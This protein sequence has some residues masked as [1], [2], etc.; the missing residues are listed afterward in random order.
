MSDIPNAPATPLRRPLP[1]REG[2]KIALVLGGGN[3][4]GAY[5]AGL[6]QALHEAGIE[7]DWV[8]GT[9]IGAVVGAV[10]AGNSP[11]ER[12][13]KLRDLWRPED[14]RP[15]PLPW[16]FLPDTWR[17]SAAA[18]GT[19]LTG[20]R[21]MF[22]PFGSSAAWW[23]HDPA[24]GSHAIYDTHVLTQTLGE[25]VNFELLNEGK[26][27]YTAA[28]VY[29]QTGEEVWIDTATQRVLPDHVRASASLLSAFPGIEVDGRL[30]VDG[31]LSVNVPLDPV[32][33]SPG[34][35]PVLCIAADLLPLSSGRPKTLGEVVGRTQDLIFAAQTR[36]TI[37]G[38]KRSFDAA[39]DAASS[40]TLVNLAYSDQNREIAGKAM[41]FSPRS[42]GERWQSGHRDG[43]LLIRRLANGDIEVG[44]PGLRIDSQESSSFIG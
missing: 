7:P 19:L 1:V 27:R 11:G 14:E 29:A 28:A 10:I 37:A 33:S 38:W 16:D 30:L 44:K 3:A 12:L 24:A 6:Y 26:V 31:G 17:R 32:L 25:L 22:G 34:A 23:R 5:H 42:A 8:L 39:G 13:E 15:A 43:A 40:V 9:S 20:R 41:D 35:S 18:V 36:R 21:G 4:L 2:V